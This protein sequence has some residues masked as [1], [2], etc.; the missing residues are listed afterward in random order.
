MTYK[1]PPEE[2]QVQPDLDGFRCQ[3]RPYRPDDGWALLVF[4]LWSALALVFMAWTEKAFPE[5]WDRQLLEQPAWV[6]LAGIAGVV[7]WAPVF[8]FWRAWRAGQTCILSLEPGRLTVGRQSWSTSALLEVDVVGKGLQL[9]LR[10]RRRPLVIAMKS[11]GYGARTWLAEQIRGTIH[12][13]PAAP[14]KALAALLEHHT[15]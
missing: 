10:D 8:M 5:L 13:T 9:R 15:D 11:T 2:L 12:R 14:P 4:F 1:D 3:V 6:W 7:G